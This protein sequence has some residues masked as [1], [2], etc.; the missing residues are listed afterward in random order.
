LQDCLFVDPIPERGV[1]ITRASALD[2][3]SFTV[4]DVRLG[5]TARTGLIRWLAWSGLGWTWS[6]GVPLA[7]I[8]GGIHVGRTVRAALE[9][10]V[11]AYRI[12]WNVLT[13]EWQDYQVVQEFERGQEHDWRSGFS[14]RIGVEVAAPWFR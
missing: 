13:A 12:P 3:G 6:R 14:F 10:D 4:T 9:A 11:L 1:H 2:A 7:L 5:Y 8:G